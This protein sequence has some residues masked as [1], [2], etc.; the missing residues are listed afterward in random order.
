MTPSGPIHP[1]RVRLLNDA[2]VNDAG[3]Y[4]LYW[5][6]ATSTRTRHNP[7]LE[8]AVQQANELGVPPVVCFGLTDGWPEANERH[9]LFLLQGLAAVA[10][11]LADRGI[12]FVVLRGQPFDA[13]LRLAPAAKLV[14]CDRGYLRHQKAWTTHAALG[15]GR[16]VVQVEGDVVVPVNVASDHHESA[17]RTLRPKIHRLWETYLTDLPET[18]VRHRSAGPKASAGLKLP[19]SDIDVT[20]PVAALAKLDLPDRTVHPVQRLAG[21]QVEAHRLLERFLTHELQAYTERRNEPAEQHSSL[22]SA[23]L[24]FGHVSPVEL[25]LAVREH[26]QATPD[27]REKYLEELIVRRELSMNFAEYVPDYDRYSCLPN[28]AHKT[29]AEHAKDRRDP[30]YTRGQLEAAGTHDPYWNAAMVEMRDTGFMHNYMRMYWGKKVLEWRP[31]P[32]DAYDTL[33][34]INNKFFLCGRDANS[35]ANVAWVFGLH[36]RAWGPERPVFGKVRYM[37][38]AGLER[39]YDVDGYVRRVAEMADVKATGWTVGWA[40]PTT[41]GS[42]RPRPLCS[43]GQLE[44]VDRHP[45]RTSIL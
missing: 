4:V 3:R 2:P 12:A 43:L 38:A 14:V 5:M 35:Y 9:Y 10:R 44:R 33:L 21:G 11:A 20:D 29:L 42:G 26:K 41:V 27:D 17:A 15:A 8:Y 18:P 39:K 13:P 6:G 40:L 30:T 28:W 22:M 31:T 1:T 34:A 19:A 25:A 7:A 23:Y 45:V 37:N 16:R 36:D 32:E 24:H